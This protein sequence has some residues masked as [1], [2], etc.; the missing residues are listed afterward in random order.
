MI[1]E[2]GI[3][4]AT[5]VSVGFI[6]TLT[7]PDHYLPFI[8]LSRA[9]GWSAAKTLT[10]TIACGAGHTGSSLI[11]GIAGLSLGKALNSLTGIESLRGEIAAW[12]L[13]TFGFF[14]LI[15]GIKKSFK[16]G[17]IWHTRNPI[18][19]HT[20]NNINEDISGKGHPHRIQSYKEL[21]PWILFTV[22]VLGPCEPF[23]PIL[24]Y[25]AVADHIST[26]IMVTLAFS[27]ATMATMTGMVLLSIYGLKAVPGRLFER[28]LHTIAGGTILLCGMGI[29]FLG[30]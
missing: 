5:A 1:N 22:F 17:D 21:T 20:H 16:K 2:S 12:C 11:I 30:I 25:P 10:V 28:H 9:R 13:I 4:I 7:G 6:H 3:L 27:M 19:D 24:L 15:W 18:P 8:V 26:V 14:Y 23:I 29:K